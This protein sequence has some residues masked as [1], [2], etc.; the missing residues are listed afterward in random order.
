MKKIFIPAIAAIL[1]ASCSA[2]Y[3]KTPSGIMYKIVTSGN[4]PQVKKGEF[5]KVNFSEKVGDSL[6]VSSFDNGMSVYPKVDSVGAIYNVLEILPKLHKGDSV[7]IVELGDSLEKKGMLPPFMKHTDKRTWCMKVENIFPSAD[8]MQKDL[9][10]DMQRFQDKQKK[11]FEDFVAN[12]TNLQKTSS[13]VYVDVKTVGNGPAADSGKILSVKYTG[14]LMPSGKVFESNMDDPNKQPIQFPMGAGGIIRGWEDGL[15]LFHAG[16]KGTMYIPYQ[17][18]YNDQAGPGGM[19]YQNLIF[20]V[21]VLDVRD[22]PPASKQ[23]QQGPLP[24]DST[25]RPQRRK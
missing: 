4:G 23:Q 13:G 3:Q 24:M 5:L 7:V 12:K 10:I 16:G 9:T 18:A 25:A 19:P 1:L 6:I 17:L 20:D 2:N 14:K 15:K 22:A 21:E 8:E 11:V